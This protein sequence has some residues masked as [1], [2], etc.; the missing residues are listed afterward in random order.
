MDSPTI[1]QFGKILRSWRRLKGTSQPAL[2]ADTGVS[3][4]HISFIETGRA[5]PSK[6]LILRLAESLDIPPREQNALL[7][8]AGLLPLFPERK[9]SDDGILPYK[10]IVQRL[11]I[12]H[13]P[14]PAYVLDRWWN[15]LG[16]NET[17]ARYLPQPPQFGFN[18]IETFLAHAP[19][20][21]LTWCESAWG[22]LARVRKEWIASGHDEQLGALM[23]RLETTPAQ[24]SLRQ[25]T[26]PRP[27]VPIL[28][29][30]VQH[31]SSPDHK[32]R[33]QQ[34]SG[35]QPHTN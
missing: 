5:R 28:A 7:E 21:S 15:V 31:T 22:L 2:A 1:C 16:G 26:I 12:N 24:D 27:H 17:A 14:Y 10:R 19:Q 30:V 32:D 33:L 35:E 6:Q 25:H 20:A 3:T 9:L 11:L 18:V 8:S 29:I 4:R 13:E 23:R 34:H